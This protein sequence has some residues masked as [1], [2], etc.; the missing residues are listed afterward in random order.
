MKMSDLKTV[1]ISGKLF[2]ARWMAD[3]N[4]QFNEDNDRYECTIGEISEADCEKLKGLGIKIKQKSFANN[5]IVGKSKFVFTPK[6]KAGKPVPIEAIGNGTEV[7][8]IV[9][10]YA[11]KMSKMHGNAP[12]IDG[13][14]MIIT[15]LI[16]YVPES[17]SL[18]DVL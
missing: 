16:T 11:H 1:K 8:V 6:T 4:K 18:E 3:I 14:N 5:V 17:E 2:W 9:G 15:N 7:S 13:K 10:S 12:A